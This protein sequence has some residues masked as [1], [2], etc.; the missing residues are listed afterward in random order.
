MSYPEICRMVSNWL[1][2]IMNDTNAID[3]EM[4][5]TT[6]DIEPDVLLKVGESI[7][8]AGCAAICEGDKAK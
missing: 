6:L 1:T 4:V 7:I 3:R 2:F 5:A 8:S